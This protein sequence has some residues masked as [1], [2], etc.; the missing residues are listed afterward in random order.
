MENQLEVEARILRAARSTSGAGPGTS[1][2]YERKKDT[3]TMSTKIVFGLLNE[4]G[5]TRVERD[6]PGL[7]LNAGSHS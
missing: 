1:W 6:H 3:L 7:V 2:L 4:L 5:S